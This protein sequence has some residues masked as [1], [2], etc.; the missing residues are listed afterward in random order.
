MVYADSDLLMD[1]L[2]VQVAQFLGQRIPQPFANNGDLLINTLDNLSGGA[3]LVSIRSRGTYS[4]PFTRVIDLQRQAD[5]RLRIEEAELLDRLAETEAALAE[6]NEDEEGNPI[7]QLTPEIQAEM[8]RFNAE[9]LDTR[10]RLRD[11]QFQLTED[12]DQLG[13]NLKAIN[14]ALIPILLTI[15]ALLAHFG[16]SR[17][18][19]AAH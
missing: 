2:W 19:S 6:L 1:R 8:D 17:R 11:V 7:G 10:R 16:R 9:L 15:L 4:R 5:D 14:T 12:I 13:S 18:R 3:D